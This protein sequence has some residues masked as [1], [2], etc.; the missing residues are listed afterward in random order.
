MWAYGAGRVAV[1]SGGASLGNPSASPL[2]DT[3]DGACTVG[4]S[5]GGV[6]GNAYDL[7]KSRGE[8]W[9]NRG[10]FTEISRTFIGHF[11]SILAKVGKKV[12]KDQVQ[13]RYA[14]GPGFVESGGV[15]NPATP[16]LAWCRSSNMGLYAVQSLVL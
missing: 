8:A 3:K 16:A 15:K 2:H 6:T 4:S 13:Y 10:V 11:Y 14:A 7:S 5:K 12:L 9:Q 1:P